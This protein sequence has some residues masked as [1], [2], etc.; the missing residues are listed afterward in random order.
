MYLHPLWSPDGTAIAYQENDGIWVQPMKDGAPAG[1]ARLAYR[2]DVGRWVTSWTEA[3]GLHFTA[4]NQV[5]V[6]ME[7]EV[8]PRTA[9][10]AGSLPR[11][12]EGY[13]DL[14]SFRWSPDR[15]AVAANAW[16][17]GFTLYWPEAGTVKSFERL[18]P[19]GLMIRDGVWSPDGR[20][21][22]YEAYGMLP[23]AAAGMKALDV[24]TGAVRQLFP[25]LPGRAGMISLS[26]DGSTMAFLRPEAD[27]SASVVVAPAGQSD[28]RVV[29]KLNIPGQDPI[30]NQAL[31]Q[32][33]PLG[34]QV[35]Y[36]LQRATPEDH[37]ESDAGSLWVVGVDGSAPRNVA[38]APA[39]ESA[40]WDP[41]GRFV[42]FTARTMDGNIALRVAEVATGATHDVPMEVADSRVVL[43][44]WSRD[45]RYIGMVR[46]KVWWEFWAVQGLLDK[47]GS[48]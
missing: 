28:G 38:T 41:T 27:R 23:P 3:A 30:N 13:P 15:H 10:A 12:L 9:R 43:S 18:E 1:S 20:E 29:V 24:G 42:A 33:S 5:N 22:W 40:M 25:A 7:V 44:D 32:I 37:P 21:I 36:V 8:D 19:E 2:T 46:N 17:T 47:G 34:D 39:I 26:T 6:P 31:P 14:F 11:D 35:F 4:F 48:R 45:G 16:W